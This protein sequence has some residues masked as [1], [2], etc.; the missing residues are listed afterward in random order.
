MKMKKTG[1]V[2]VGLLGV[3]LTA[4]GQK[5]TNVKAAMSSIENLKYDEALESLDAAE[6]N[7]ENDRLIARARGI[8]AL[9][10]ADYDAAKEYF[11]SALQ[12][13]DGSVN[14]FEYDTSYYLAAAEYKSGDYEAAE[15]TYSAIL[16]MDSKAV[17]AYYLRGTTEL[18][19]EKHDEALRDF[20]CAIEGLKDPDL[21][22]KIFESLDAAG[23]KEEG[24]DYLDRAQ[25]LDVKLSDYQKGRLY[26]CSENYEE[27]RNYLEKARL[28]GDDGAVLYLGRTYEAL[29]DLNYAA[30]LY[31]TYLEKF[32]GDSQICNQLGL[33]MLNNGDYEGA[34]HSFEK[35][36][37]SDDGSS[38]QI[39]RFNEIVAYEKMS[40]FKKA[41]VL[42]Q[43]YLT[44]YPD[45]SEAAREYEFLK[46]R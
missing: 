20:N 40:D 30:S 29:G 38:R 44:D 42:M 10:S 8:I 19:M 6:Q 9:G 21:Y 28:S 27:A 14:G 39:L 33:C 46:T 2:I 13:G 34:L 5:D 17:N 35:G 41:A 24:M 37:E 15:Q 32:P 3:M 11:V 43:T 7:K 1:L 26:F 12:S 23:Y 31:K 45:D 25:N 36:L 4:C 18:A 16:G 22:I